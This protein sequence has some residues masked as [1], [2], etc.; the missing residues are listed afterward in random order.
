MNGTA[1]P[2]GRNHIRPAPFER[3]LDGERDLDHGGARRALLTR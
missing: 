2:H 1:R 3:P